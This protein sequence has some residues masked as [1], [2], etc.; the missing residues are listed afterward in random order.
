MVSSQSVEGSLETLN[1]YITKYH[2]D[3][4]PIFAD[5]RPTPFDERHQQSLQVKPSCVS[6][7]QQ[8]KLGKYHDP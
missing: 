6:R 7:A 1:G 2:G 3:S 5:Q 8:H 4:E